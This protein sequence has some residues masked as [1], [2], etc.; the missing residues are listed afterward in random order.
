MHTDIKNQI[1]AL[2]EANPTE[3]ICGFIYHCINEPA[4]LFPCK[5][6]HPHP[7]DSFEIHSDDYIAVMNM[8]I[9]LGVYH[10]HP[11]I[12]GFSDDD[13]NTSNEMNLPF[14]MYCVEDKTFREY[15]PPEYKL[16]LLGQFFVLGFRDCYEIPRIYYRQNFKIYM[17]D[18]DRDESFSHEEK[19]MIMQNYEK[20]G[21]VKINSADIKEGDVLIFRSEKILPQHFGVFV[22]NSHF[23]H[24]PRDMFSTKEILTDRW[25]SRLKGVFRHKTNMV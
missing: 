2:A 17:G 6:I 23:I 18:Y 20:E 11:K 3:E 1:I 7:Q 4:K 13:L 25:L 9:L 12:G 15:I 16:D 21:F 8:G 10:S 22:G 14:Y 24:H 5:N 19:E